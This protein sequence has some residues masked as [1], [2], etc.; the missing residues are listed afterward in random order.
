MLRIRLEQPADGPAVEALLDRAFGPGRHRKTSYRYREGIAPLANLCLVA[1]EAGRIVG[2]I[3]Y[4]PI[5]LDGMPALL[6]GP[7]AT[8]PERRAVGIGRALVFES[9]AR[10]ADL[11]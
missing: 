7:V 3:R 9:L 11:G 2:T 1:E 8:D 4:W 10:A 6:L 5:R